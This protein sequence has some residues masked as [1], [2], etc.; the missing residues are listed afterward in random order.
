MISS[1]GLPNHFASSR[2]KVYLPCATNHQID[3]NTTVTNGLFT[4]TLDFGA[5]SATVAAT[6]N[7]A[8]WGLRRLQGNRRRG[9]LRCDLQARD[10]L[11][12][13]PDN[14][15][16]GAPTPPA[17]GDL[18]QEFVCALHEPDGRLVLVRHIAT[19]N[20]VDMDQ[21]AVQPG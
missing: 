11:T 19:I 2:C 18:E 15:G 13:L 1:D 7:S 9:G 6:T 4:A 5:A 16:M 17:L 3:L 20:V 8:S 14:P 12:I 10:G 21:L